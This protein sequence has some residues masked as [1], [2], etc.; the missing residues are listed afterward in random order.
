MTEGFM[1]HAFS[2]EIPDP[3][4][5]GWT[6]TVEGTVSRRWR[7]ESW[8]YGNDAVNLSLRD[9]DLHITS[10]VTSSPDGVQYVD[11]VAIP[12]EVRGAVL[13]KLEDEIE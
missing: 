2:I 1:L 11:Y 9:D 12:D 8:E 7:V 3:T 10:C 4:R 6:C 5:L 13:E